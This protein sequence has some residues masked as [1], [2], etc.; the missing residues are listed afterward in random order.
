M[1]GLVPFLGAIGVPLALSDQVALA[2]ISA[3]VTVS[4][5]IIGLVAT[6]AK[7]NRDMKVGQ[8]DIRD[9]VSAP[10]KIGARKGDDTPVVLPPETRREGDRHQ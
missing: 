2:L 10:R 6:L 5:S 9:R 4:V 3:G 8:A 7:I 1:R